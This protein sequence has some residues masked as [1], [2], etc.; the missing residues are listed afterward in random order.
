MFS[1]LISSL[2]F[3]APDGDGL[4]L[5]ARGVGVSLADQHIGTLYR[6]SWFT[7]GGAVI[8]PVADQ[9]AVDVEVSY[10]RMSGVTR[11]E[12]TGELDTDTASLELVPVTALGLYEVPVGRGDVYAGVGWSFVGFRQYDVVGNEL[13]PSGQIAGTKVCPEVRLGTRLDT[14]LIEAPL[15]PVGGPV[16]EALELE[17]YVSRRKQLSGGSAEGLDLSAWRFAG[18]LAVRF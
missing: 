3:A 2:A 8:V 13:F 7:G 14:G 10:K 15:A 1:M 16:A 12:D 18:G 11:D 6:S 9:I 4:R 5:A 17:L